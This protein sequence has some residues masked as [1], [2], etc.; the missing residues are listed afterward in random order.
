MIG[1]N[2]NLSIVT[3]YIN[4]LD[5]KIKRNRLV[6]LD[7]KRES[8]FYS[9]KD[10]NLTIKDK[11]YLKVNVKPSIKEKIIQILLKLFYKVKVK[12]YFL[13]KLILS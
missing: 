11:Y 1:D 12:E 6:G 9:L 4:E 2:T 7:W 5:F 13:V 10:K 8:I 3:L